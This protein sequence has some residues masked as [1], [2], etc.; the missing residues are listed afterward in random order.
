MEALQAYPWPGNVRELENIVERAVILSPDH[1]LVL[2][3]PLI[4]TRRSE[5]AA[6]PTDRLEDVE[7]QHILRILDETNWR[8]AG[9]Q[10]AADRLG[11]NPSTLRSRMQKWGIRKQSSHS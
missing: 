3:E 5:G 7:R 10:G 9:P 6:W 11:L 8:I 2:D 1:T 4:A